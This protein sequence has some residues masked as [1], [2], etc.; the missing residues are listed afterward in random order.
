MGHRIKYPI[1]RAVENIFS[2]APCCRIF[3]S[4]SDAP[5]KK[6]MLCMLKEYHLE[7]FI[8]YLVEYPMN[9]IHYIYRLYIPCMKFGAV[10]PPFADLIYGKRSGS[11][12]PSFMRRHPSGKLMLSNRPCLFPY[13][14]WIPQRFDSTIFLIG[15]SG[16]LK[17]GRHSSPQD[18]RPGP[19]YRVFKRIQ[20]VFN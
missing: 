11:I 12:A 1:E 15:K 13:L 10:E 5:Y 20:G 8:E 4:L 6:Y 16:V 19:N 3:F 18:S 14:Q 9:V 17:S 2:D 7:Y